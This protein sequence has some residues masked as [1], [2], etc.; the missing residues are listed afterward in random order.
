MAK[1]K[2]ER[3]FKEELEELGFLVIRGAGSLGIDLVAHYPGAEPLY[4]EHKATETGKIHCSDKAEQ[5]EELNDI[6]CL[7]FNVV[8]VVRWKKETDLHGT[9]ELEK[10][11]VFDFE[12]I[13]DYR[14]RKYPV[15]PYGEGVRSP[16]YLDSI[17]D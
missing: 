16:E 5:F 15:L 11:F 1:G 14:A 8:Y 6:Y 17:M 13:E 10:N 12:N 2:Y 7:G 3:K 9:T 4:I